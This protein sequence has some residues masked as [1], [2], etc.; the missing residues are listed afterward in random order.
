MQFPQVYSAGSLNRA[1]EANT[2]RPT[3]VLQAVQSVGLY[4][5]GMAKD[6]SFDI[7]TGVDANEV[8]NAIDQARREIGTR[9]DFKKVVADIEYERGAG[10]FTVHTTDEY[11]LEAIWQVLVQRF[12]VRKVPLKNLRRAN[13]E[14]AARGTIRQRVDLV[15][16]ID[17]DLARKIAK[18]IRDEKLKRIQ[19]QVHGDAV[20]VS[21]PS[22]DA[23]QK[24]IRAVR[25]E[26]W[27][28]ELKFGNYR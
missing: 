6:E 27:G 16:E 23:L 15:Q 12:A 25:G 7:S 26:D 24:V 19:S 22:R 13:H 9:F 21:G 20:R 1:I 2:Q 3:S 11:K 5:L 17:G 14:D 8:A 10:S 28:V 18:F 4:T